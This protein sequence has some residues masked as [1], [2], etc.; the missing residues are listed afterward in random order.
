MH[1]LKQFLIRVLPYQWVRLIT[2]FTYNKERFKLKA[3][4]KVFEEIYDTNLWR[5]DES[6]SGE[7]S[8]LEATRKIREALP[9]I[10]SEYK[11]KSLLDIPCG[12]Y[13]WMRQVP[14]NCHYTGAD[15]VEPL[16]QA[17]KEKY[18]TERVDFEVIDL[19]KGPIPKVDLIFSKDCL[20][21]L[22]N[23]SV[24]KAIENILASDATYLLITNYPKTWRNYDIYDG[25]YRALNLMI[26]P[27]H[28]PKPLTTISENVKL[29]GVEPD[30]T[31]N[32]YRIADL[33]TH[34][35][36]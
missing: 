24:H 13:N 25:D 35:K 19:T 30:K 10:V 14:L 33:R 26:A 7:G 34:F 5:S 27:F 15:V 36:K 17:N 11:I 1:N 4:A 21:H 32:L 18:T 31:M 29:E 9:S 23:E 6:H 16:I 20:Q 22:S 3:S 8:T 28:F 2:S 12:D